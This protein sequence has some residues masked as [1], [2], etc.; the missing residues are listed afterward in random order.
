MHPTVDIASNENKTPETV[1]F[2]NLTKYG[3]DIV[4]QMTR[5]Y[6]VRSV[7]WKWQV[8]VLYNILD[9]AAMNA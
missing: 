7:S 8:H 6:T 5:L 4:D 3:V 9:L 1:S 2:Y